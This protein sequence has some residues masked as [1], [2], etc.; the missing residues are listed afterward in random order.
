LRVKIAKLKSKDY[1]ENGA[2]MQ[3]ANY[4]L[5]EGLN[6]KTFKTSRAKMKT[7]IKHKNGAGTVRL[8]QRFS[9]SPPSLHLQSMDETTLFLAIKA[10]KRKATEKKRNHRGEGTTEP[11]GDEKAT[12]GRKRR[13]RNQ[14]RKL[15]SLFLLREQGRRKINK[16]IDRE[17]S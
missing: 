9:R 11:G 17:R 14:N 7:T 1:I 2:Q 12:N 10:R 15:F 4:S 3:G 13:G 6:Y 16:G 8:P 5:N